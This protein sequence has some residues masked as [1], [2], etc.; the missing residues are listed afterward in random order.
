MKGL[1]YSLM[2]L[3]A[4]TA[5]AQA[6][7]PVGTLAKIK[8]VG[9]IRLG[10]RDVSVPFSYLDQNQKPVGFAMDLCARIVDAV[11]DELKLPALQTRLQPI[12]LST[13]IPLIENGTIDIVCGPATNTLERQKVVAFSNTIFVSSIRAVVR[14]DA[15]I[16][17]FEDLKDKP[18]ALTTG[19]TSITLLLARSQEKNFGFKQVLSP[20]H[21]ASFLA[22]TTGRSD[23]F[24]MDDI[25]LAGLIA[26]SQTPDNWRIIDDSLRTEPYGLII[27]KGDPEF[28]ALI[29]KTL[30]AMMK[31][32]EFAELYAKWFTKPIPPKNVNLNFPMPTPLK[33]AVTNP[34]D[35][36]V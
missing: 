20:D 9:E 10:H 30:V 3:T 1:W 29:D 8:E 13:Q 22:L 14:K 18:V 4:L 25:L 33:D 27:R 35:K 6:Q 28:K 16:K 24:V 19:S 34:N 17:T 15:P 21:A 23:A 7:T 32:G 5:P 36:G 11:K 2:F 31:G 12:Q 26:S